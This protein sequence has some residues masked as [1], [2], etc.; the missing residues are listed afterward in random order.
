MARLPRR[1]RHEDSVTLVEHLDELRTR[2]IVGLLAIAAGFAAAFIFQNE[3]LEWLAEPLPAARE[4]E[5]ITFG[6]TEPFFTT[7]KVS[8]AAGF[9]F[10]L[11]I[12]LWQL[13]NFLAPAFE[14][15]TQRVVSVF[16]FFAT[17]LF[18]AGV[19]FGYYVVLPK[20][21]DF[22]T[23]F[24]A[25]LFEIQIRA[26]Y[27]YSFVSL[28]LLGIGL[29]FEL[30]VFILALVRLSI[31]TSAQLRRNWRVGVALVVVAAA[32]LPT[33][34]PVSLA[35]EVVPLLGLYAL[36]V[37]LAA[38]FERRWTQKGVLG[39]PLVGAGEP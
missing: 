23:N 14:E 25:D 21:L 6:V 33:V 11:P 30:P 8:L 35:F 31:V 3:I 29:M 24:N 12:V 22:L 26:S 2:L 36:S 10:A 15:H 39:E 5:L 27:Y 34:D 37:V 1:L 19:A 17:L 18:A 28:G 38:F 9:A 20:A 13:W 4:G 7:V 32:L 16:V